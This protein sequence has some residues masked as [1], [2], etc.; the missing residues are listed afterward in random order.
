MLY[1]AKFAQWFHEN[2]LPRLHLNSRS[3]FDYQNR[4][5]LYDAL[6]QEF[7]LARNAI[8]YLEFGVAT[9]ASFRWWAEHNT[10]DASRFVGFD[11]F[12]GLPEKWGTFPQGAFSTDGTA[13][14]IG[15]SRCS[16]RVGLFHE[17]L[18]SFMQSFPFDDARTVIHMDADLYGSTVFVLVTLAPRLKAGDILIFD[19]FADVM[20]EFRALLDV[21][22]SFPLKLR[23]ARAANWGGHV[24]F[25]VQ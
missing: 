17:T 20:N 3:P 24:A 15:D 25:T 11:T 23:L 19:E 16:F 12:R 14:D 6:S 8:H 22:R 18:P 9:G 5:A 1:S 4:Y 2:D 10:N 7:S 21:C 13:P